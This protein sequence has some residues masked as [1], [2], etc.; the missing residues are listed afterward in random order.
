MK[1]E[2][3]YIDYIRRSCAA[4]PD[5]GIEGIGDDCA[6]IPIG[7]GEVL[8]MTADLLVEDIHFL[9][10]ATSPQ[11]LGHKSL[12]VNLSDVAAMGARPVATLLSVALP[13]STDQKWAEGFIDGYRALSER[14]GVSLIGGDTTASPDRIAINVTAIGRAPLQNIKRRRDAKLQGCFPPHD[15][16]DQRASAFAA[17]LRAFSSSSHWRSLPGMMK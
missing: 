7:N 9:R 2:F 14:F 5:N 8:V 13:K 15:S 17:F 6:V 1:D 11:M 4:L 16:G 10:Q 12:A 3:A